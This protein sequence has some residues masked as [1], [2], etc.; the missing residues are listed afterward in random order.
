MGQPNVGHGDDVVVVGISFD[1][2]ELDD[3]F[4]E[5]HQ[6]HKRQRTKPADDLLERALESSLSA[7]VPQDYRALFSHSAPKQRKKPHEKSTVVNTAHKRRSM[8]KMPAEEFMRYEFDPVILKFMEEDGEDE[9]V[10]ER[11]RHCDVVVR[12]FQIVATG[13]HVKQLRCGNL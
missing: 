6:E 2:A 3:I 12:P 5:T 11:I 8:T 4:A 7:P 10:H 9:V 1:F 13:L